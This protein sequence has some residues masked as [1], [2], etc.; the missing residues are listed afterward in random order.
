LR[1]QWRAA[2]Q[3]ERVNQM[4]TIRDAYDR[5]SQN[6]DNQ[7]NLTR[8]LDAALLPELAPSLSGRLVVEVGC[9]TGKNSQWLATQCARLISVDFSA[10]ML[11]LAR[12]RVPAP[13]FQFVQAD[14]T[15]PWPLRPL[16]F[17]GVVLFNLVLEHVAVAAARLSRQA[18]RVLQ[19]RRRTLRL[20]IPSR[21]ASLPAA[22][23]P[24]PAKGAWS[25]AATTTPRRST[26]AALGGCR[27]PASSA[28]RSW[29]DEPG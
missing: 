18:A 7:R 27:L 21:S 25:L 23:P 2:R 8:D 4:S 26:C 9:G 10:D 3:K 1:C 12:R 6:Y 11:Q 17:A 22:A 28:S 14:V 16:S 20:R 15:A 19:P 29:G 24:L 13:H 5:W